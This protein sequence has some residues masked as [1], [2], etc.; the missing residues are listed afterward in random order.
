VNGVAPTPSRWLRLGPLMLV[1]VAAGGIVGALELIVLRSIGSLP[2][3][4]LI[5]PV[6]PVIYNAVIFALFGA[7]SALI[8]YGLSALMRRFSRVARA[9]APSLASAVIVW[10]ALTLA[11]ADPWTYLAFALTQAVAQAIT[12]LA[13]T[14]TPDDHAVS[15]KSGQSKER[16]S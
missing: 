12:L 14:K 3:T 16:T 7:V 15:V 6:L 10:A 1:A 2:Q 4:G 13:V 5:G 9:I 11:P 8:T